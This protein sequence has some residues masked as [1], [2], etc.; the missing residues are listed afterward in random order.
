M[1][2]IFCLIGLIFLGSML[3]G[4]SLTPQVFASQGG[5]VN[6]G[7]RTLSYTVGEAGLIT[8]FQANGNTL[9]QGFQQPNEIMTGLMEVADP[10]SF[11]VYPCPAISQAWIGFQFPASGNISVLL[12]NSSG[13]KVADIWKTSYSGGKVIEQMNVS[14]FAAGVYFLMLEFTSDKDGKKME[15]NRKL[16]IVR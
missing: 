14:A 12:F 6:T 11:I 3:N 13:Q 4:Q 15:L 10:A 8:T 16:E 7:T 1:S 5:I 9:T 2:K